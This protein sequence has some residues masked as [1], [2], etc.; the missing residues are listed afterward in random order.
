MSSPQPLSVESYRPTPDRLW[1]RHRPRHWPG[2]GGVWT[3]WAHRSLGRPGRSGGVLPDEPGRTFD[4]VVYLPPVPPEL[5]TARN[6]LA[7]RWQEAGVPLV[8]QRQPGQTPEDSSPE[9]S[10][11]DLLPALLS[12]GLEPLSDLPDSAGAVWPLVTGL[13]DGEK[14]V[15]EGLARLAESEVET[16]QP[17]VLELSSS[18]RR[19]LA[20][21]A[22]ESTFDRI[23]HGS[24]PSARGFSSRAVAHGLS[25]FLPRPLPCGPRRLTVRRRCAGALRL[26][27]ELYHLLGRP[28]VDGQT[29]LRSA[30]W[31]DREDHDLAALVA[32]NNLSIVEWFD[33]TSRRLIEEVLQDG[34][35]TLVAALED[36]YTRPPGGVEPG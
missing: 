30:R 15:E 20:R 26:A 31:I 2:A 24:R 10:V 4:D 8:V 35:S 32:E 27:A 36:E 25:P 29:L 19:Q 17:M 5:A 18:A 33:S 1:I 23:F 9:A 12:G 6:D 16:V 14:M 3:D 34:R 7:A 21:D 22:D 28:E 11:W 13:T